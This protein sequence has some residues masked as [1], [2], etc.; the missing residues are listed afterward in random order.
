MSLVWHLIRTKNAFVVKRDGV[1]LSREPNNVLNKHGYRYSSLANAKAVSAE[2]VNTPKGE[3]VAIVT[4]SKKSTGPKTA[5]NVAPLSVNRTSKKVTKAL[6]KGYYR[7]DVSD[8]V[9]HRARAL[10]KVLNR[11]LAAS[12]AAKKAQ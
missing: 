1:V 5:F 11:R 3:K 7:R 8:L 2:I 4:K 10:R 6:K 12:V 9:G